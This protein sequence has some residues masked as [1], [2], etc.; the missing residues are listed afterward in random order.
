MND[1]IKWSTATAT[2]LLLCS[3]GSVQA[4]SITEGL[5]GGHTLPGTVL[6]IDLI[7]EKPVEG[8]GFVIRFSGIA[9]EFCPLQEYEL[10]E[11]REGNFLFVNAKYEVC[12]EQHGG[13]PICS[14][15]CDLA[16]LPIEFEEEVSVPASIWEDIEIGDL[17]VRLG[18]ITDADP[19]GTDRG[20]SWERSF[21][22]LRGT[23]A[24]P[25]KLGGGYWV[26]D[27]LPNVGLLIQQEGNVVV[28]YDL[29][30]GPAISDTGNLAA[31]WKYSAAVFGGN[32]TNGLAIS[33]SKPDSEDSSVDFDQVLSSSIIVDDVNNVRA[34]F[35]VGPLE[36]QDAAV[37]THHP[38]RRYQFNRNE[39][40]RPAVIPDF[41]GGWNLLG[42]DGDQEI[43]R[44][45]L[46]LDNGEFSETDGWKFRAVDT[47][48]ELICDANNL[49][50]GSC[51]L[52]TPGS[53][54][55]VRFDLSEFNGNVAEV[56]LV[57]G[58]GATT[59]DAI[60]LREG[61]ELP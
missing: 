10:R 19:L 43:S 3:A 1:K 15:S 8:D 11:P 61:F 28:F 56:Q 5:L 9:H 38:F 29:D 41:S 47:D 54:V 2:L 14:T 30:Y 13:D 25:P 16:D 35:D 51:R 55:A 50:R 52:E 32:S 49:G 53:E 21:D 20:A 31:S 59:G 33:I 44:N 40:H 37:R 58:S 4:A 26:R 57:D 27:D 42:F 22:L 39:E 24:I 45:S 46:T 6:E 34:M 7:P 12:E 23:H 18:V 48:H 60:L 36:L 17:L